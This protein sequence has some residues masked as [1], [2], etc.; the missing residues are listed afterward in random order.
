MDK[1]RFKKR[2]L[3]SD[4]GNILQKLL[5]SN[6][7]LALDIYKILTQ[8]EPGNLVLSPLSIQLALLT[9]LSGANGKTAEELKRGLNLTEE[10]EEI[11]QGTKLLLESLQNSCLEVASQMFIDE[12]FPM[13]KSYAQLVKKY[14]ESTYQTVNFTKSPAKAANLIN[15][16]VSTKTNNLINNVISPSD[17]KDLTFM[18]LLNAVYFKA[19]WR[20]K[21]GPLFTRNEPFYLSRDRFVQIPMMREFREY[22]YSKQ[23]SFG[24]LEIPYKTGKDV[25]FLVFLPDEIDG[26]PQLENALFE[27]EFHEML[28]KLEVTWVRLRL[29]KMKIEKSVNVKEILK[30]LDIKSMFFPLT[31]DFFDMFSTEVLDDVL[32]VSDLV[33]K[34]VLKVNEEGTEA[35][36]FTRSIQR[37]GGC[38]PSIDFFVDRPF[39]FMIVQ[40]DFILFMGRVTNPQ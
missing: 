11:F 18:I 6:S 30:K 8:E 27:T 16:W 29:P 39:L 28:K 10:K 13:K 20:D 38:P 3:R 15:S 4:N 37:G 31:A 26:L 34:A 33:H 7:K 14:F 35:S 32:Y 12:R 22:R 25:S 2:I 17:L 36:A 5:F 23:K 21:F 19:E 24:I 9:L 40:K 1:V